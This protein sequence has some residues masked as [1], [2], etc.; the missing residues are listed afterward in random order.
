MVRVRD[1]VMCFRQARERAIDHPD[2]RD[3]SKIIDASP[4]AVR[5]EKR[6][7]KGY[8]EECYDQSLHGLIV[9][10]LAAWHN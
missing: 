3:A 10:Q 6:C 8:H 2:D 9:L 4:H 1:R 5:T 7:G